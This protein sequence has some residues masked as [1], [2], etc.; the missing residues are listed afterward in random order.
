VDALGLA[1]PPVIV[2]GSQVT[3]AK[4]APDLL[5]AAAQ[6]LRVD[7]PG[8][9]CIGDST[10]DMQAGRSAGM[11]AIAVTAGAAV[12]RAAL[13]DAGAVLVVDTLGDL[14]EALRQPA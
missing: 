8:C 11:T 9:W 6:T 4:P 3:H 13:R 7:P 5:L 10:W 1:T 2:D 12:D 14:E